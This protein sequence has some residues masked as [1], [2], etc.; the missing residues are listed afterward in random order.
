M[1]AAEY[2]LMDAVEEQMWWYRALHARLLAA[3]APVS[4]RVL[5]AG[6]GTG[7][8]LRKL[9]AHRVDLDLIGLEWDS[10]AACRARVK[11]GQ[12]VVRG[13]VNAPPFAT[14]SFDAVVSADVLCH[15][16]VVLPIA[17]QELRRVLRPGGLLVLNLPAYEWLRSAHDT[18][19]GNAR[20]VTR[21][22]LASDLAAAGFQNVRAR[23][24]NGVLL[25]VMAVRRKLT[26]HGEGVS[27]VTQFPP[28]LD[29][30]LHA[31][32]VIERWLPLPAGGSVLATATRH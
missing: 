2:N 16:A 10:G 15:E 3:L 19:V 29:R 4:G 9:A 1:D 28:L 20:R 24:W 11:S 22:A 32:T 30:M 14:T 13:S 27:D 5:D 7:G 17:L 26:R 18:R 25:P 8:F 23:Y 31:A 12:A 21:R 6:C